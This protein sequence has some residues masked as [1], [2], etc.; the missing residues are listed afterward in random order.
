MTS[1]KVPVMKAKNMIVQLRWTPGWT[2]AHHDCVL[3]MV[4]LKKNVMRADLKEY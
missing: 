4:T 1:Q 2:A 3:V